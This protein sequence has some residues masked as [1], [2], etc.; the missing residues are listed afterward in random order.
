MLYV[1]LWVLCAI[2][3]GY[4][5]AGKQR[6]WLIGGIAGLVLGPLGVLLALL[7]RPA[8]TTPAQ[9]TCPAC[10]KPAP[11]AAHTCPTCGANIRYA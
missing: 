11:W 6:S 3:T 8:P 5:Y 4:I 9:K 2:V 1:F 10:G 7:T